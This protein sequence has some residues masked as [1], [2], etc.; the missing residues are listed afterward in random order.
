MPQ[1]KNIVFLEL[2]IKS[3]EWKPLGCQTSHLQHLRVGGGGKRKPFPTTTRPNTL[4]PQTT[5][6]LGIAQLMG[7]RERRQDVEGSRRNPFGA[8]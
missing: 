1:E 3:L 2:C 4:L 8:A 5:E 6:H 7:Y